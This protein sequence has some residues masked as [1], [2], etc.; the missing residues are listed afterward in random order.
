M[1]EYFR[2]SNVDKKDILD[3]LVAMGIEKAYNVETV[4]EIIARLQ[5]GKSQKQENRTNKSDDDYSASEP[6]RKRRKLSPEKPTKCTNKQSGFVSHLT[7]HEASILCVGDRVDYRD[8][9]GKFVPAKVVGRKGT[10]LIIVYKATKAPLKVSVNYSKELHR[11]ATI[12]SISGRIAHRFKDLER[13]DFIDVNPRNE[14]RGWKCA[15]IKRFDPKS[16]QIE[17]STV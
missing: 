10:T 2:D 15:M 7:Q 17:V 5:S 13:D 12:G 4:A 3:I 14:Q 11:L 9:S 1:G 8:K 16:G 6:P